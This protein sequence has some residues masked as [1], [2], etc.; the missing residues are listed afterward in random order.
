MRY[1][2]HF[3]IHPV[4]HDYRAFRWECKIANQIIAHPFRGTDRKI[5]VH[6]WPTGGFKPA[7]DV[8]VVRR[9][10]FPARE[11]LSFVRQYALSAQRDI[12]FGYSNEAAPFAFGKQWTALAEH[13]VHVTEERKN[14]PG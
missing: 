9:I 8:G 14:F 4:R 10:F 12:N 13:R 6:A 11:I 2:K 1:G 5:C 7:A 3:R